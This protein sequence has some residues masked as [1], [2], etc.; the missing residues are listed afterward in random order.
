MTDDIFDYFGGNSP[1]KIEPIEEDDFFEDLMPKAP[2]DTANADNE[3]DKVAE[4]VVQKEVVSVAD[5]ADETVAD[6][7]SDSVEE[8]PVQTK[9]HWD[10]L[11]SALGLA[12]KK[13]KKK[14]KPKAKPKA[15]AKPES[16][17]VKPT[18]A[19]V[20]Q[21]SEIEAKSQ[22]APPQV[23]SM[24]ELDASDQPGKRLFRSSF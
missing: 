4:E 19:V 10:M 22:D 16:E 12:P 11:A 21:P 15:K 3:E 23:E 24:F 1:R 6:V 7:E 14:S 9:S 20:E 13:N 18:E 2:V 5:E 8:E 17:K